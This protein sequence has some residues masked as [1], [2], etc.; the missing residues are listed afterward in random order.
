MLWRAAE[1]VRG[2]RFASAA[3][4]AI[5]GIDRD[6]GAALLCGLAAIGLMVPRARGVTA[7]AIVLGATYALSAA[8]LAG[9]LWPGALGLVAI[10]AGALV[11]AWP[12]LVTR[13]G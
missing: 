7:V 5:I 12:R 8:R 2:S 9:A 11:L 3:D 1:H 10:I 13:D 6:L 4:P